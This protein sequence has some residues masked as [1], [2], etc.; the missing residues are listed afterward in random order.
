MIRDKLPKK[1]ERHDGLGGKIS[2]MS[3]RGAADHPRQLFESDGLEL[4][5][6]PFDDQLATHDTSTWLEG[7]NNRRTQ[8]RSLICIKFVPLLSFLP[9]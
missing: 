2:K 3:E 7:Q 1:R 4:R 5:A 6:D 9:Q 8:S